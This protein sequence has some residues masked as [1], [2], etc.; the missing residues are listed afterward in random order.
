MSSTPRLGLP[1]LAA[2]QAQKEIFHNEALQTLDVVVGG[3]VEDLPLATP[4]AAPAVGAC[5][6]IAAGATGAWAGQESC[7]AAFTSG[8]W[9]FVAPL[10]GMSVYVRTAGVWAVY[11]G[12]SWVIGELTG[13][14]LILDGQQVVGSRCAAIASPAGGTTADAEG[15]AAIDQ[16]LQALREH[17]LIEP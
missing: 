7:V 14:R 12:A 13:A 17:G 9:R 3:A 6:I 16:I 4:P 11:R 5:Y 10:E 1:F 15:R 2:G 8:G